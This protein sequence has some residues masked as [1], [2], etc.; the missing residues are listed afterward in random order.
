MHIKRTVQ[1][2]FTLIELMIVVAIIGILAAIA[3]PAYQDYIARSQVSEVFTLM[4]G[5]KTAVAEAC[6]N[7][8]NCSG[9]AP[10]TSAAAGKYSSTSTADANGVVTGTMATTAS[11][12]S[13]LVAGNTVVFTPTLGGGA[14]T[15]G[16]TTNLAAKYTPKSCT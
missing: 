1:Q 10:T 4:D 13:S 6:Q 15:W 11:G 3:L 9:S 7:N 8:G 2:G 16:C 12:T 5:A 14:V